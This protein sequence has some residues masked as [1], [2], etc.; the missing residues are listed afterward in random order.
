MKSF[1]EMNIV[2]NVN[3]FIGDKIKI[4]KILDKEIIIH[5]FKINDSKIY[6]NSDDNYKEC[7][8]LQLEL[9]NEKHILFT[10]A[11]TLIDAIK[12]VDKTDFP[13]KTIIKEINERYM[14]T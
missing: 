14:F 12:M 6:K 5:D 10:S 2:I 8:C 4:K 13:F 9:N 7:L 1:G 3:K 11:S